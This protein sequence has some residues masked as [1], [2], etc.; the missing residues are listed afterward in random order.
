ME[1]TSTG[2][3]DILLLNEIVK[4]LKHCLSNLFLV[5]IHKSLY[6]SNS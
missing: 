5:S 3:E 2:S 6:Y 1:R 4:S